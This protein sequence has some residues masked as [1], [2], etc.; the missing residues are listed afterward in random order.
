MYLR[1]FSNRHWNIFIIAALA[2]PASST[3]TLRYAKDNADMRRS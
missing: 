1:P 3:R 2:A